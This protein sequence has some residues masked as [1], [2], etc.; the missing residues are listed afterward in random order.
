VTCKVCPTHE[1]Y[2]KTICGYI[3]C[4]RDQLKATNTTN[5]S[6]NKGSS[7]KDVHIREGWGEVHQKWII[8]DISEWTD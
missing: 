4:S 5:H 3:C 7:I 8:I 6:L 1:V 2:K